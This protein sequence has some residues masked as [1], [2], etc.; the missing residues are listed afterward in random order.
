[1]NNYRADLEKAYQKKVLDRLEK[2]VVSVALLAH[3]QI[4]QTTPVDTGR[5]KANWFLDI[6]NVDVKLV[7][8]NYD[9]EGEAL[10][11]SQSYDIDKAIFISN[12]L[13]YIRRLNE[14]Y[15]DQAPAGFVDGA[16]QVAKRKIEG[17]LI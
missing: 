12:N 7:E 11:R 8:P 2:T 17:G 5:A 14:G 15:S 13:P 16:I 1:M 6:N 3:A 10:A 9:N 4:V